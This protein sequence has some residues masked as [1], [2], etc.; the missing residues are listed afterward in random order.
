MAGYDLVVA[1]DGINSRARTRFADVF[2]P[3]IDMRKCQYIWLGTHQKFDD[4]F[5]FIFEKPSTAGCGFIST[6][7]TPTPRPSSSNAPMKPIN[8][9]ASNT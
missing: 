2:K 4:A 5:T 7:S 1:P 6:S 8:A 3:D 9:S